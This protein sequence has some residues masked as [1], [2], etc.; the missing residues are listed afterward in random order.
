M[1]HNNYHE[2]FCEILSCY[3]FFF[4]NYDD[5]TGENNVKMHCGVVDTVGLIKKAIQEEYL[6]TPIAKHLRMRM[7]RTGSIV[8]D[9]TPLC[10]ILGSKKNYLKYF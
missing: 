3:T 9:E 1:T 4:Q 6:R 7:V 5:K 10:D 8:P 2:F